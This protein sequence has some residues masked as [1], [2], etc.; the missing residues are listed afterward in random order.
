MTLIG[1]KSAGAK[2]IQLNW[3]Q[4]FHSAQQYYVGGHPKP[5]T[6]RNRKK[7]LSE[8]HAYAPASPGL[9]SIDHET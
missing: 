3:R 8:C 4:R 6:Y 9:F 7:T 1:S 5:L 2:L